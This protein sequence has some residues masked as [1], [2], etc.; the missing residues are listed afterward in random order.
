MKRSDKQENGSPRSLSKQ[1]GHTTLYAEYQGP[2][3][4]AGP[5]QRYN[6]THPEASQ[7]IFTITESEQI[8]P[9]F[10]EKVGVV[11]VRIVTR[12]RMD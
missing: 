1:T 3:P 9:H 12:T 6:Q 4:S 7:R 8:A 2:L 10:L 5:M 11:T